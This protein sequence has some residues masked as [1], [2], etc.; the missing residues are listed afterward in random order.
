MNSNP[1]LPGSDGDVP[2]PHDLSLA[3]KAARL[4]HVR[5]LEASNR[6]IVQLTGLPTLS[7]MANNES[8]VKFLGN[9]VT[10][11]SELKESALTVELYVDLFARF[12]IIP[13]T[14][15]IRTTSEGVLEHLQKTVE[16]IQDM[17]RLLANLGMTSYVLYRRADDPINYFDAQ[18]KYQ[19]VPQRERIWWNEEQKHLRVIVGYVN[20]DGHPENQNRAVLALSNH[21][22]LYSVDIPKWETSHQSLT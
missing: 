21:G 18:G 7:S 20:R 2:E 5:Q 11:S 8:F 17:P 4:S 12:L 14:M 9:T 6:V 10:N 3:E 13:E 22:E 15:K 19:Q 16:F 1:S